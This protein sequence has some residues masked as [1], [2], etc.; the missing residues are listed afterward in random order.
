VKARWLGR[1]D[2]VIVALRGRAVPGVGEVAQ[3]AAGQLCGRAAEQRLQGAVGQHD[4]EVEL[5]DGHADR[6]RG[7]GTADQQ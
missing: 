6:R 4:G 7:E 5:R 3:A 1:E 2:G